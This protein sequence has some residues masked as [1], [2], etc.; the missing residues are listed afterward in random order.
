MNRALSWLVTP[1][2]LHLSMAPFG[3]SSKTGTIPLGISR[4]RLGDLVI[5]L[6]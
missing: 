3:V 2:E 4:T 1:V 5:L 6:R